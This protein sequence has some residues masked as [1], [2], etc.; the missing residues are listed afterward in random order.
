V[1]ARAEV[2]EER[3]TQLVGRRSE[4]EPVW[5]Q[6]CEYTFPLRA[7][8]WQSNALNATTGQEAQAELLDDVSTQSANTLAASIVSGSVPANSRWFDLDVYG[9]ESDLSKRWLEDAADTVWTNIHAAN[10]DSTVFECAIDYV[11][12]GQFAMFVD[13]DEEGGYRF[14]QWPLY[15]CFFAAARR[16]SVIDTVFRKFK[17][18]A[19]QAVAQ[20]GEDKVSAET[21]KLAMDKPQELIEMGWALYPRGTQG[22][23]SGTMPIASCI[24][25]RKGKHLVR[26]GGYHEMPLIVPRWKL[27]PD[28]V[29]AVGPTYDALPNIKTLNELKALQL[30]ALDVA[31]SG[32]W[33]AK[34]D[35][36]LNA[37]T[38]K[39][40]PRKIIVANDTDSMKPLQSGADFNVAFVSEERLQAAIRRAYMADQLQPQDGPA[41]T[42]TEVHARIGLI[43]QLLGPI[44]GRLQS[45]FLQPLVER[46]F[47]LAYRAGALGRAPRDLQGA[48]FSVRYISPLARAQKLEEVS[49]IERFGATVMQIAQIKPEAADLFDAEEG[50]RAISDALGVPNRAVRSADDVLE[51]RRIRSEQQA[52]AQQQAQQQAVLQQAAG[53]L[54]DAGAQRMAQA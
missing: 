48:N 52:A 29:Y 46:C 15:E 37:R 4:H 32:M 43:R 3:L 30:A 50:L 7:H 40:G 2:L 25:E 45:E 21:R 9:V 54:I 10:F 26:E 44:F 51:L 20:F 8:G 1:A 24:W 47:G 28:G 41:M 18:T 35:G 33:I 49:A 38:I 27:L 23:M 53:S 14:D 39:L 31:V 13:E 42:A 17:I 6:C 22:I 19:S 11:T 16:G 36:V 34:D 12:V 5:R